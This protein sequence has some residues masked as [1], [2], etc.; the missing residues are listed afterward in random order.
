MIAP[1]IRFC[2]LHRCRP[3]FSLLEVVIATGILLASVTL[4]AQL[5]S[6]GGRH[7]E[8]AREKAIAA[9]LC[10]NKMALLMAGIDPMQ[11]RK[12]TPLAEDLDWEFQVALQETTTDNLVELKVSVRRIAPA[13]IAN[14]PVDKPWF[15]LRRW[16]SGQMI[17]P[18]TSRSPDLR[19]RKPR[20]QGFTGSN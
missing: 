8:G 4:L 1:M 11:P 9:R 15:T 18:G 6:I 20:F 7:L 5:T 16:V 12:I 3:A 14:T 13:E 2:R 17:E 19:S 10:Q